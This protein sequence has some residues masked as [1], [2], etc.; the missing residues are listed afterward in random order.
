L[1]EAFLVLRERGERRFEAWTAIKS[2]HHR[3]GEELVLWERGHTLLCRE[4][5]F[6]RDIG[7]FGHDRTVRRLELARSTKPQ[8]MVV[9]RGWSDPR[10]RFPVPSQALVAFGLDG[11]QKAFSSFVT[12]LCSDVVFETLRTQCSP[13]F[14]SRTRIGSAADISSFLGRCDMTHFRSTIRQGSSPGRG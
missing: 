9:L 5:E 2:A 4:A 11:N 8:I 10:E 3:R 7:R 12:R 13:S 6:D 14:E 1:R